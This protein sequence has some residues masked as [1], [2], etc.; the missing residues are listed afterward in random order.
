[1]DAIL[2]LMNPLYKFAKCSRMICLITVFPPRLHA[3]Q[4]RLSLK[5]S[6]FPSR[7]RC[8]GKVV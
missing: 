8:E 4:V 2:S 1:M 7:V 3:L 6:D 5:I